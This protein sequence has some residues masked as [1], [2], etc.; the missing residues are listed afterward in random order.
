MS[1]IKNKIDFLKLSYKMI[2]HKKNTNCLKISFHNL[3]K[4]II[5]KLI[6]FRIINIKA[7]KSKIKH[8]ILIK[9]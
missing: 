1:S 5:R 4:L 9:K 6:K 7:V 2:F 3:I 8:I